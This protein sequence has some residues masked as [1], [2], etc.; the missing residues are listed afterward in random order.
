MSN[1]TICASCGKIITNLKS[2]IEKSDSSFLCK[3][4]ADEF[5]FPKRY[6]EIISDMKIFLMKHME[7]NEKEAEIMAQEN[8]SQIP[9]WLKKSI[10]L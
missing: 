9:Y 2:A 4:C 1:A 3:D 10:A 7:L 6:S 5:G 8:I